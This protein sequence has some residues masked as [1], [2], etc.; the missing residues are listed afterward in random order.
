MFQKLIFDAAWLPK[1]DETGL[2]ST[3]LQLRA[4]FALPC[5]TTASPLL[6]T[7][8]FAE[9]ELEPAREV[10]LPDRLYEGYVQFRWLPRLAAQWMLDLAITPGIFSDFQQESSRAFRLPGHGVV[11][12]QWR[13]N[14]K[15]AL[16]AAYLDRP[17]L[18]VIPI[19]G[20]IWTPRSNLRYELLFPNSKIAWRIDRAGSGLLGLGWLKAPF[21]AEQT[22]E[23][24]TA[25]N[26][27][28]WMYLAGEFMSDAWAIER[29][30]GATDQVV[31]SD[32][33][34]II[35]VERKVSD[36]IGASVE[37]GYV[38]SRRVRYRSDTP[39]YDPSDTLMLR[40][41]LS[42]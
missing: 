28:D 39:D 22:A 42:Y 34:L 38:F 41:R 21:A 35:G 8:G 16:G 20:L 4:V 7:P 14:V 31:L 18:D 32:C 19:G 5:P 25:D 37:F 6:I 29:A 15:L 3:D 12:W 26:Q 36:G 9:H 33:R 2:G 11:V 17:D 24:T 30:T 27:Q 13:E 1:L 40:G 10:D 23:D